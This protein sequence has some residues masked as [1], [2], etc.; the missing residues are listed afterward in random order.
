MSAVQPCFVV[1][2]RS[3]PLR[4]SSATQEALRGYPPA[5]ARLRCAGGGQPPWGDVLLRLC[6]EGEADRR[7]GEM[8][9]AAAVVSAAGSTAAGGS[10]PKVPEMVPELFG[11]NAQATPL[12]P[13]GEV[14]K[15]DPKPPRP[16]VCASL[17]RSALV[18]LHGRGRVAP[19]PVHPGTDGTLVPP[20]LPHCRL[21]RRASLRVRVGRTRTTPLPLPSAP[22]V[23][24]GPF[25][26]MRIQGKKWAAAP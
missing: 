13:S 6:S 3:A 2:S 18:V 9:R 12:G 1:S 14:L 7:V 24:E 4:A 23:P 19:W 25:K 22:A 16:N 17:R 11:T 15:Y 10:G 8:E 20:G 5:N 21:R 26:E